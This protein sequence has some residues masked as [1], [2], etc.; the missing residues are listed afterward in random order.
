MKKVLIF[1]C[2]CFGFV[3]QTFAQNS[4]EIELSGFVSSDKGEPLAGVFVYV[5]GTTRGTTTDV[6]G[7][8]V[9]KV[10]GSDS[11]VASMIGFEKQTIKINGRSVVDIVLKQ[12]NYL[13]EV[14]VVGYGT[15][16][17]KDLVG[18]VE[19]I[20][21][22][23]LNTGSYSGAVRSL[24]GQVPGLTLEFADGKPNHGATLNIRGAAQ[25]IG[26]GG[27][28]LVLVDGVEAGLDNVIP[29][30]I[31]SI[32]VLK[33]ASSCA[34]YGARGAFGVILVTTKNP[35]SG[36]VRVSYNGAVSLLSNTVKYDFVTDPV[37]FTQAT[38][39]HYE[40][41]YGIAPT[42]F[43][44]LF[45]Y[46]DSWFQE[47]KRR[48]MDPSYENYLNPVGVGS[49]GKYQYYGNTDWFDLMYKNHTYNTQHTLSISGGNEKVKFLVS[50]RYFNQ[51]GIYN[52]DHDRYWKA[53][54]HAKVSVKVTKWWTM[55]NDLTFYRS[56]YKQPVLF[57][58]E[59]SVK[60]QIE[61]QAFPMT[62]P[63]NPDGSFT[64]AAVCVGYSAFKTGHSYQ[65][66]ESFK[67]GETFTNT[68][69]II[70]GVFEFSTSF[71]YA[72]NHSKRDRKTNIYG[73]KNGPDI[74]SSRPAWDSYEEL[75]QRHEYIKEDGFFTITPKLGD[76]HSLKV[77]LGYNVENAKNHGTVGLERNLM[78]EDKANF[79]LTKADVYYLNDYNSNSWSFVGFFGRINYNFKDKYLIEVSGRYDGSS[80]FPASQRWGF[81]PSVSIGYRLSE[82]KFMSCTDSWLDNAKIRLS[83]GSLGNGAVA[84]Y[85]YTQNMSVN[86]SSIYIDGKQVPVTSAPAPIPNGLTWEKATT[87]DVGLDLDLFDNRLSFVGDWY[88]RKTT[89]MFTVGKTLPAVYGN[90]APKGN[91][92]DMST[93]GWELSLGWRDSFM[94]GG[95]A[96]SYGIKGMVW[97]SRSFIDK[98]NNETKVLTDYYEGMELGEIWGMHVLGLFAS[99]EDVATSADQSTFFTQNRRGNKFEPGDLKFDD[100]NNDG[101][102]NYGKNTVDDPG[103]MKVIGNTNPR[104]K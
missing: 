4:P 18:A 20:K 33:D 67:L 16:K 60:G 6:D 84:P 81:F 45:P 8:Y 46:S 48:Y 51:K 50:G 27:S 96:F 10:K 23:N 69:H 92:A 37:Y 2:L 5:E 3:F 21:G 11:I 93:K 77:T 87:Y 83:A 90:N 101:Y 98:Y 54:A 99:D 73:F 70:P 103:D 102:I 57:Q 17:R 72:F 55:D 76:K 30:D 28:T 89:D 97:D 86:T 79:D 12:E 34:I 61:H 52:T 13:D 104:F 95:K 82:E 62:L 38:L 19:Q 1:L 66:N 31:A 15:Q 35:D 80:K 63:Y 24:Q 44:N 49:D 71:S 68:F 26:S 43:N 40:G 7:I 47:L 32:T 91:Y 64:D 100:A 53:N 41:C 14:V 29:E 42:G 39:D 36:K 88:L 85:A 65:L 58:I 74:P 56:Y 94:A 25:S 9:L 59:Q 78:R 75:W 22:E